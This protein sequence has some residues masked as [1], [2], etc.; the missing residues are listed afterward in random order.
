MKTELVKLIEL[1]PHPRNYKQHPEDQLLHIEQ[2]IREHGLYRPIVIAKDGT[3]LAG[4]GVRLAAMRVG[5]TEAEVVRLNI[6]SDSPAAYKVLAGDNEISHLSENDDRALTELLKEISEAGELLGTGFDELML[7]NLVMVTRP[8]GE[9]A[10]FDEAAEWVG[11][12]EYTSGETPIKLVVSFRNAEDRQ[13]LL[14]LMDA[15]HI[16]QPAG[17]DRSWSVWYP[18]REHDDLASVRFDN[19]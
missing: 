16:Q 18:S 11:L 12:P 4:H 2:M 8:A 13:K 15:D 10:D 9:I 17:K 14:A 7:A 3:V 1:K 5:I 6:E 19:A